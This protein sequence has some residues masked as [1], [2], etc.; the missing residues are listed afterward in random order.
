MPYAE[1]GNK[2]TAYALSRTGSGH[3]LNLD[4]SIA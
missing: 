2:R 1:V 4:F 3:G